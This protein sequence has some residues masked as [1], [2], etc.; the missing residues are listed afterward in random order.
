MPIPE[1]QD[2][3]ALEEKFFFNYLPSNFPKEFGEL[4]LIPPLDKNK[5]SH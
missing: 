5:E 1:H 3:E 2:I 4:C